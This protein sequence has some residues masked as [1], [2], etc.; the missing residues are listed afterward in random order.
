[1]RFDGKVAL[2]TG[3]ARGIG[4][5]TLA[6]RMARYALAQKGEDA[7]PDLFGRPAERLLVGQHDAGDGQ[8]AGPGYRRAIPRRW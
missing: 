6:Y 8:A 4:K 2:V 7:G 3:G 1:M 5:A